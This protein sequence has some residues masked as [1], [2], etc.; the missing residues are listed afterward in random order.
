M[1][2]KKNGLT[3]NEAAE[4]EERQGED[5]E[6]TRKEIIWERNETEVKP[7]VSK[8][9]EMFQEQLHHIK[10]SQIG[11][12]SFSKDKSKKMAYV[13][14]VKKMYKTYFALD[15]LL[16][17]HVETWQSLTASEQYV[18]IMHELLHIPEN[19]FDPESKSY[20]KT[21]DHDVKDFAFIVANFGVDWSDSAKILNDKKMKKN[22]EKVDVKEDVKENETEKVETEEINLE[23]KE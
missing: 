20:R 7:I 2:K 23:E 22:V 13:L 16:C 10:P 12:L 3:E 15:Y 17:V 8:L 21:V 5:G 14:P 11:Y 4:Q 19:G 6:K 9:I 18:L 1:P